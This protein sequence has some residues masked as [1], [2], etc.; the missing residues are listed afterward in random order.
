MVIT[1]KNRKIAVI[2]MKKDSVVSTWG[3]LKDPN[4]IDIDEYKDVSEEYD[5]SNISFGYL[6]GL[7]PDEVRS[8]AAVDSVAVDVVD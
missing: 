5:E 8:E 2:Y 1:L 3:N 7:F 4:E 6:N